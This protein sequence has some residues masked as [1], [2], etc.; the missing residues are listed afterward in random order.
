[1]KKMEADEEACMLLASAKAGKAGS[2]GYS[3]TAYFPDGR[4]LVQPLCEN[5]GLIIGSSQGCGIQV[6]SEEV[7]PLHCLISFN[8]GEVWIQDWYTKTGT[9][10]NGTRVS[11]TRV[12]PGDEIQ[13][14]ACRLVVSVD[15]ASAENEQSAEPA[16]PA[17]QLPEPV[18]AIT[19]APLPAGKGGSCD[20]AKLAG[21]G[22]KAVAGGNSARTLNS[23]AALEQ[24]NQESEEMIELL[25]SEVTALQAELA[26][27]DARIAEFSDFEQSSHQISID[28]GGDDPETSGLVKRLEELLDELE[29]RDEREAALEEMLRAAEQAQSA[30]QEERRQLEA[31]VSDVEHR[32][33]QREEDWRATVQT[34]ERRVE[35]TAADRDRVVA[36]LSEA[37]AGKGEE[38]AQQQLI[39]ELQRT[40]QE[41]RQQLA[42]SE[43]LRG[44]PQQEQREC[45]MDSADI[46][47]KCREEVDRILREERLKLAQDQ[48]I[49]ARQRAEFEFERQ[50]QR[51]QDEADH[52]AH[53]LRQ[54]LR[55][56]QKQEEEAQRNRP[57]LGLTA[58]IANLWKRLEG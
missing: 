35:E 23:L 51:G 12:A 33:G 13:V 27:R 9:F 53:V 55:E 57:A 16:E 1:V 2:K 43:S 15:L 22:S 25:R 28:S 46:T 42:E 50:G 26:E 52:R 39:L 45:S 31:W 48:A 8:Q 37:A 40:V 21:R 19:A 24:A 44:Q 41:L 5:N 36:M 38:N 49:F 11:E 32:I 10:L 3:V 18:Q 29:H 17:E 6:E 14:G 20:Q 34:L 54:H 7:A 30:E 56:I 58:R 47:I 4:Q